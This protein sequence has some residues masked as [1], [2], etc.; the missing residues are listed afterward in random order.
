MKRD[1]LEAYLNQ[2]L[3][4]TDFNDY[5]PNGL[6]IEGSEEITKLI[7]GVTASQALI[8]I[9]VEKSA[10]A[11]LVHHG[12]FWK[13]EDAS[14]TGI[15]KTRIKSLLEND[16]S[17]F[18]YHLPL[19][20]HPEFGNNA[21]LAKLFDLEVDEAL[22]KHAGHDLGLVCHLQNGEKKK[23]SQLAETFSNLLQRD[24]QIL[25]PQ[26]KLISSIGL[27]T[28]AAQSMFEQVIRNHQ[29]DA[30]LSGEVSEPTFH[31]AE[32][33]QCSYFALGH[34][35]SERYGAKALGEHLQ[36]TFSSLEVE[37]VDIDNPV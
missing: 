22:E 20:A 19:D 16:I 10:D 8:D 2:L 18:A 30:F 24:V 11:I 9:A 4:V 3:S 31:L 14:V 35:A 17:L 36:K 15:K 37:F 34:H 13:G 21:Q 33:Y 7:S 12:Y 29:V 27:C 23:A 32:E 25:G 28:G 6:Q 1:E 26:D 5:C